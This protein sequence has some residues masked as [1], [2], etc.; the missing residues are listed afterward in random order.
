MNVNTIANNRLYMRFYNNKNKDFPD[1]FTNLEYKNAYYEINKSM[2]EDY[3]KNPE[4]WFHKKNRGRPPKWKEEI[5]K[6]ENKLKK[7]TGKFYISFN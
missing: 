1:Y 4:V 7:K 3:K 5:M 2:I 6:E